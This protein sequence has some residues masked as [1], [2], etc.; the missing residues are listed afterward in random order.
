MCTIVIIKNM[1]RLIMYWSGAVK[2]YFFGYHYNPNTVLSKNRSFFQS[3]TKLDR[4]KEARKEIRSDG[5]QGFTDGLEDQQKEKNERSL[6][7]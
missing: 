2:E 1:F 6:K 5:N 4:K 7:R 3:L